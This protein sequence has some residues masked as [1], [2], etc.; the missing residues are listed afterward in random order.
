MSRRTCGRCG[1]SE[2]GRTV[3]NPSDDNFWWEEFPP[4][5]RSLDYLCRECASEVNQLTSESMSDEDLCAAIVHDS[6]GYATPK[7]A[8]QHVAAFRERAETAHCERA[9]AL[10]DRELATL[11]KSAVMRWGHASEAQRDRL[12]ERVAEWKQV[13]AD[14]GIASLAISMSYPAGGP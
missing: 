8:A 6:R 11:I 4:E 5:I 2:A 14:S 3:A 10:F 12:R 1:R 7:H 9:G 13:E